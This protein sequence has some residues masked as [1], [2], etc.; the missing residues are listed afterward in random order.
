MTIKRELK[1]CP[2]CGGKAKLEAFRHGAKQHDYASVHCEAC[3]AY[4][5]HEIDVEYSA[6]DRCVN[7]WNRR[8]E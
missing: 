7:E 6:V 2:F 8:E 1:P 5:K 4:I 3:G